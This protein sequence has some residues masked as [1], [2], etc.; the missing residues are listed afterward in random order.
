MLAF[1]HLCYDRN[2]GDAVLI[3]DESVR[4]KKDGTVCASRS[5]HV[6]NSNTEESSR[7]EHQ[8]YTKHKNLDTRR[9]NSMEN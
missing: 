9:K 5:Q 4:G 1:V 6:I 2:V 7:Y 8:L 3:Y